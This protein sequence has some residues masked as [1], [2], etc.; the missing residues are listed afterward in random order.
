MKGTTITITRKG[1]SGYDRF[2]NATYAE[3]EETV[4]NVLV[5]P[6][7]TSELE[8]SRPEGVDVAYS[9][10]FP[11]TFSGDLEGCLIALPAPWGG[12][13]RV[14]GKPGQYMDVNTPTRWHLPV[15]VEVAH[16]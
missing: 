4:D 10:H 3:M 8:A 1:I 6:G 5:A 12:T 7:S 15:E 14:I 13:Y 9:L 16:G 11:K 2:G